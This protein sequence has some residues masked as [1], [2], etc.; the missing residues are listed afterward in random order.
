MRKGESLGRTL[1]VA[2]AIVGS[3]A[4]SVSIA[5]LL[6]RPI[7]IAQQAPRQSQQILFAAGL[8]LQQELPPEDVRSRLLQ[9]V[10]TRMLDLAEGGYAWDIDARQYDFRSAAL[11]PQT[12]VAIAESLDSAKLGH[13]SRYMPAYWISSNETSARVV[14]PIYGN[15][16]WSMIYGYIALEHDFNTIAGVTFYEHGET[17]GIGDQILD[18]DWL[19]GWRRKRI[20]DDT[21]RLMIHVGD[22][23]AGDSDKAVF[24]IDGITGATNTVSGIE[25][26]LQY[27]LGDHGYGPL[28]E[29][30]RSGQLR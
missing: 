4:L 18:P 3:C 10:E 17:P 30:W 1:L 7:Q 22:P 12:S 26:L 29:K 28:L 6:L 15:G 19:S 25:R 11:V 27:W 20:H 5:V 16:M 2:L 9:Q 21:G 23:G 8:W 13:R 24:R 14:L